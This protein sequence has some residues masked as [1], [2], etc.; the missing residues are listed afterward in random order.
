MVYIILHLFKISILS[1]IVV[2]VIITLTQMLGIHILIGDNVVSAIT[3]YSRLIHKLDIHCTF[4]SHKQTI[5]IHF[6]SYYKRLYACPIN[7]N[8]KR[9]SYFNIIIC[10]SGSLIIVCSLEIA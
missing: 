9:L 6:V 10:E 1:N 2:H 3:T 4:A 5:G 8:N 7:Y